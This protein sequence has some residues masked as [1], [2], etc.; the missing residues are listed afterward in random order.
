MTQRDR[1][2]RML[3]QRGSLGVTPLDFQGPEVIDGGSPIQRLAPRIDE[4]RKRGHIIRTFKKGKV[5]RYVLVPGVAMVAPQET[6]M[7]VVAGVVGAERPSERPVVAA[8]M[9]GRALESPPVCDEEL[10]WV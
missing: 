10:V 2:E 1:V 5:A 8:P 7:V 9:S 3:H 6:P 4:L